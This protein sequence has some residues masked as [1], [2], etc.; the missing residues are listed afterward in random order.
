MTFRAIRLQRRGHAAR[1]DALLEEAAPLGRRC[2]PAE[3]IIGA[4]KLPGVRK[5]ARPAAEMRAPDLGG[6]AR[7]REVRAIR[8]QPVGVIGPR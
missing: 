8:V 2:V 7:T 4:C 3:P 5:R 1:L 6:L